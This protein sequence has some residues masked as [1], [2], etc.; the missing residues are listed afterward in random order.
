VT[1]E[2]QARDGRWTVLTGG[3]LLVLACAVAF[4]P[5][6]FDIW[7]PFSGAGAA[8]VVIGER[9]NGWAAGYRAAGGPWAVHV[10][11]SQPATWQQASEAVYG[12]IEGPAVARLVE[13]VT[14][15]RDNGRLALITVHQLRPEP[16][17]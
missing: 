9:R 16:T 10:Q 13:L 3:A 1:P 15:E 8:L 17:R 5:P 2:V 4:L 6:P 14:A 7:W 11:L 12:P